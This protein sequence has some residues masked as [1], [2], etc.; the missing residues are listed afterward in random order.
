[1]DGI[2]HGVVNIA[3]CGSL[4]GRHDLV[5]VISAQDEAIAVRQ[6]RYGGNPNRRT[7]Q[8]ALAEVIS[9]AESAVRYGP[10]L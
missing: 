5:V 1:M 2:G 6:G 10:V 4:I 8:A 9:L 7:Q 3:P